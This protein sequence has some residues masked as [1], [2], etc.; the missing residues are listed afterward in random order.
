MQIRTLLLLCLLVPAT[1]SAL[2]QDSKVDPNRRAANRAAAVLESL[3]NWESIF[4]GND[5]SGWAGDLKGYEVSEW[6][7]RLQEGWQKSDQR[8]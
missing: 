8:E 5:L 7:T 1:R 4:N 6:R 3:E 2:G